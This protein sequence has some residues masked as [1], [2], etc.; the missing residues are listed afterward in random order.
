M[1]KPNIDMKKVH[2]RCRRGMLELD[3]LLKYFVD[4]RL[5]SLNKDELATFMYLIEQDDNTLDSWLIK[6]NFPKDKALKQLCE[7]IIKNAVL[8]S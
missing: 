7:L 5:Y 1:N 6:H 8:Y 2:W 4:A 3:L